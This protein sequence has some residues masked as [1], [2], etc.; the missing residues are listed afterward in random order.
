MNIEEVR[1]YCLSKAGSTESFPFDNDTLVFK[2]MG[3]MFA[4]LPLERAP[5]ISLKCEPEYAIEL[6]A[7]YPGLIE[8]AYH[9]NKK[10]WNMVYL[11][12]NL[13]E[14]LILSLIDHSYDLIVSKLKK[15]DREKLNNQA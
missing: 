10:H 1:S 5:S 6:R 11:E 12:G 3:K 2:V 14:K 9:M 7:H 4:L 13:E 15:A 8:G